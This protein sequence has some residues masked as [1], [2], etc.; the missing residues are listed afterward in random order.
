MSSF[1][2]I[3]VNIGMVERFVIIVTAHRDFITFIMDDV[4]TY[5]C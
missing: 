4:F 2:S 3:V 5:V 1:L